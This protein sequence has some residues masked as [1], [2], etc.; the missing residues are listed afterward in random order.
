M[1]DTGV[2][3]FVNFVFLFIFHCDWARQ[4]RFVKTIVLIESESVDIEDRIELQIVW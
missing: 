1:K 4:Q 3:D 2:C